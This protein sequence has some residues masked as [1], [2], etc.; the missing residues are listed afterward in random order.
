M[1]YSKSSKSL[2]NYLQVFY[3]LTLVIV[4]L[5]QLGQALQT[6]LSRAKSG[7]EELDILSSCWR[8]INRVIIGKDL[9]AF[10]LIYQVLL[11][12]ISNTNGGHK[13]FKSPV[14]SNSK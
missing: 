6:L 2:R 3:H 1:S 9:T 13:I 4:L 11:E 14:I 5:D 7:L 8:S 10:N 12:D